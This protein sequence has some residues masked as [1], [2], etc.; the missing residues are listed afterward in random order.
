MA[1]VNMGAGNEPHGIFSTDM[2]E[3]RHGRI[4]GQNISSGEGLGMISFFQTKECFLSP[5][6]V[7]YTL[8][9]TDL[10]FKSWGQGE[11]NGLSTCLQARTLD[12][13]LY[14]MIS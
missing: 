11:L 1:L 4:P 14:H 2:T 5:H 9:Q 7:P 10:A 13:F 12:C 6:T 8:T 3:N